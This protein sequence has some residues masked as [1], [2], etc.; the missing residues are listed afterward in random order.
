VVGIIFDGNIDSLPSNFAYSD[1][2]ARAVSVE[3][4][5]MQQALRKIYGPGALAEELMGSKATAASAA[6]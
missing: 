6:K 2:Q 1:K 5:G 3:S 4:R